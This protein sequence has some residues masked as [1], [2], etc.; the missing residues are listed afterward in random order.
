[1][2][3]SLGSR[4]DWLRSR[5]GKLER[6]RSSFFRH[7]SHEF[8]TPLA[9]MQESSALLKD[10]VVG[11]LNAEQKEILRIQGSNCQRLQALIDDLLRYHME[12]FSVLNAMPREVR[13]GKV[14]EQVVAAHELTIKSE[15]LSLRRHLERRSVL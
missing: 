15:R 12:S 6:Q 10:E 5:L 3:S 4:L 11:P 1:D 9:A 14:V 2:L 8:K 13:R 7:V